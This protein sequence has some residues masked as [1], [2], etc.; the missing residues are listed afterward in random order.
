MTL[1]LRNED[2][3]NYSKIL[4]TYKSNLGNIVTTDVNRKQF[5]QIHSTIFFQKLNGI[6]KNLIFNY[7][8]KL[9]KENF[10]QNNNIERESLIELFSL[11]ISEKEIKDIFKNI[12]PRRVEIKS[13]PKSSWIIVRLFQIFIS[14]FIKPKLKLRDSEA[15]KKLLNAIRNIKGTNRESKDKVQDD[16][17]HLLCIVF[18]EWLGNDPMEKTVYTPI[19][20]DSLEDALTVTNK[21]K[22]N[23]LRFVTLSAC[24]WWD[25]IT[26][27]LFKYLFQNTKSLNN[28][29]IKKIL[30]EKIVS[31]RTL[32]YGKNLDNFNKEINEFKKNLQTQVGGQNSLYLPDIFSL[33]KGIGRCFNS[34]CQISDETFRDEPE[35]LS[36][37]RECFYFSVHQMQHIFAVFMEN[38]NKQYNKLAFSRNRDN[39][40]CSLNNLGAALYADSEL[41]NLLISQPF[42]FDNLFTTLSDFSN[43]LLA[44]EECSKNNDSISL[45]N[46][47]GYLVEKLLDKIAILNTMGKNIIPGFTADDHD[48]SFSSSDS[49]CS[50]EYDSSDDELMSCRSLETISH[51]AAIVYRPLF[52]HNLQSSLAQQQ[53]RDSC[54]LDAAGCSYETKRSF[55]AA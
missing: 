20:G 11:I 35:K 16:H 10:N 39:I 3:L 54:N 24:P 25:L 7:I 48:A 50:S 18:D 41:F 28:S 21:N 15:N 31:L 38:L 47:I 12:F 13:T 33:I 40:F 34:I 36:L 29:E 32:S 51:P 19:D 55:K 27:S 46:E 49:D 9:D 43:K 8:K 4:E 23:V 1:Q 2:L 37:F 17:D 30:Q 52:S 5:I 26:D 14:F 42:N 22:E 6:D 44:L 45:Q 53:Q